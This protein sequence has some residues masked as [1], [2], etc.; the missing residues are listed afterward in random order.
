MTLNSLISSLLLMEQNSSILMSVLLKKATVIYDYMKVKRWLK[1]YM[2]VKPMRDLVKKQIEGLGFKIKK[3]N[4]DL[5]ISLDQKDKDWRCKLIL[6]YYSMNLVPACLL[7]GC[8][9]TLIKT[10]MSKGDYD[11]N[12]WVELKP[13]MQITRTY[14]DL[15][16]N[17]SLYNFTVDQDVIL[18]C[19]QYF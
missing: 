5:S 15:F 7:E 14:A 19:V 11:M 17:E 9:A 4:R 18:A 8:I 16:K 12:R 6:A 3:V 10:A 1:T 13:L 2:T